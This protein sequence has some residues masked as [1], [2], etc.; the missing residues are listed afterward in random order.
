MK[1]SF[2][3]SA[4][5]RKKLKKK[6]KTKLKTKIKKKSSKRTGQRKYKKK[7]KRTLIKRK[8]RKGIKKLRGG[9]TPEEAA[10]LEEAAVE[11]PDK[12]NKLLVAVRK[13]CDETDGKKMDLLYDLVVNADKLVKEQIRGHKGFRARSLGSLRVSAKKFRLKHEGVKALEDLSPAG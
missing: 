2:R 12:G 7:T 9:A 4:Y 8:K 3:K 6:L 1:R 13:A 10:A 11:D 5:R